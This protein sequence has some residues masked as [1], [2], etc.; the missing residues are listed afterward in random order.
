MLAFGGA[1][2]AEGNVDA[3][4]AVGRPPLIRW[5]GNELEGHLD[6]PR[7]FGF[8][9]DNLQE[10]GCEPGVGTPVETD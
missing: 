10:P 1:G 9:T 5:R 6:S 2:S 3:E 8:L 4:S 7:F